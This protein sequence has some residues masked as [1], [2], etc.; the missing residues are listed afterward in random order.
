MPN[1]TEEKKYEAMFAEWAALAAGLPIEATE[2]STDVTTVK[3]SVT[4]AIAK[5]TEDPKVIDAR[6]LF[7]KTS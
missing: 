5:I 4:A 6:N 1:D 2:L 3:D 7:K